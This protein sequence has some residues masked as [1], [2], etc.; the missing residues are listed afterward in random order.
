MGVV[1]RNFKTTKI[2][3]FLSFNFDNAFFYFWQ[4]KWEK[5]SKEHIQL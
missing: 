3:D 2:I 5:I 4:R 1:F